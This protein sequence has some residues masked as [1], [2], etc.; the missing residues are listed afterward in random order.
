MELATIPSPMFSEARPPL[1]PRTRP[2]A[3]APE[4]WDALTPPDPWN[5]ALV[6]VTLATGRLRSALA[7]DDDDE[8]PALMAAHALHLARRQARGLHAELAA[9]EATPGRVV[10][11]GC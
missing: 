5:E 7:A 11:W 1:V 3:A 6:A 9:P 8:W 10:C 2:V 4:A